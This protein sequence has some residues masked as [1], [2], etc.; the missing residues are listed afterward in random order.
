MDISSYDRVIL[1]SPVW[2]YT[3]FP[4][5]KTFLYENDLA[6]KEIW[7]FLINGGWIGQQAL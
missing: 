6:G 7:P 4:A 3:F 1:G 2:W 5:M